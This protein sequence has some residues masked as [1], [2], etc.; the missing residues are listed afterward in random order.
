[1]TLIPQALR[2]AWNVSGFFSERVMNR[3]NNNTSVTLIEVDQSGKIEQFDVNTVVAL[4]NHHKYS[5]LLPKPVKQAVYYENKLKISDLKYK[6]FAITAFYCIKDFIDYDTPIAICREYAGNERL[7]K[8]VILGLLKGAS[9]NI[10]HTN[11]NFGI[12]T[13]KSP[14]HKLAISVFRKKIKPDITLTRKHV[15]SLLR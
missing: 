2:T 15:E 7:I 6:L 10:P 4:S 12:L 13:K 1:M 14:A 11:I 9:I 3:E 5:V 8:E